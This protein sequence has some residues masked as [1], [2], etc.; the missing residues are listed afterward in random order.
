M[1]RQ[2][3]KK[4]ILIMQW[5]FFSFFSVTLGYDSVR[6]GVTGKTFY[7]YESK[8]VLSFLKIRIIENAFHIENI[9]S[10]TW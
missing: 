1:K 8:C 5:L 4:P 10:E 2:H 6:M 7:T 9:R 3:K